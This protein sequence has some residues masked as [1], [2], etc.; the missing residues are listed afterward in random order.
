MW[1]FLAKPLPTPAAHPHCCSRPV[2]LLSLLHLSILSLPHSL[3]TYVH[4]SCARRCECHAGDHLWCLPLSLCEAICPF[5]LCVHVPQ[6]LACT[7]KR[8]AGPSDQVVVVHIA[9][10]MH[11]SR[12]CLWRGRGR[13]TSRCGFQSTGL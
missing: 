5:Q 6:P 3:D 13:V 10:I 1:S 12:V 4:L 7:P 2:S 9:M 8:T 11:P